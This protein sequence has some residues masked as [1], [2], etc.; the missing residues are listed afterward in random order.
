MFAVVEISGKQY[1]VSPKDLI[2]VDL[3]DEEPGKTL[4]FDRVLMVAENDKQAAIGKPYL[5]SAFVEAKVVSMVKGEKVRVFKF[6]AK[7]RH[8]KAQGHRQKYT[9][10]EIT[11][12]NA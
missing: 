4:K 9:Q 10:I 8:S 3:L 11:G 6:T 1:K 2:E 12:I 5:E 7:K